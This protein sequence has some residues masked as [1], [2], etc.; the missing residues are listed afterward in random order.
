[1]RLL[2]M[3]YEL[4]FCFQPASTIFLKNF[5]FHFLVVL[6]IKCFREKT[7]T[8]RSARK[9]K[10]LWSAQL[11]RSA[12]AWQIS[13]FLSPGDT[14]TPQAFPMS[15]CPGLGRTPLLGEDHTRSGLPRKAQFP[16]RVETPGVAGRGDWDLH[17]ALGVFL[18][19]ACCRKK[20]LFSLADLTES[21]SL[22][23]LWLIPVTQYPP[24]H[25]LS[26]LVCSRSLWQGFGEM[27]RFDQQLPC[28][29]GR[30]LTSERKTSALC[31]G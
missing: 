15:L 29:A 10:F 24:A 12:F 19:F 23:P 30:E 27:G 4:D 28:D 13:W 9:N 21:P 5:H 16:S 8:D 11:I 20:L 2:Q 18:R 3:N 14:T 6:M 7:G 25:R 22:F 31:Q 1:M 17:G 26:G